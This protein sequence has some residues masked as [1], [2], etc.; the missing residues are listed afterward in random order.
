[1]PDRVIS[2]DPR[3]PVEQEELWTFVRRRG[4]NWLLSAIQQV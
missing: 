4:G 3:V 1:M 2:G